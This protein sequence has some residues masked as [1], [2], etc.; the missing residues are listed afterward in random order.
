[1][2]KWQ[3][4]S[5]RKGRAAAG[6]AAL[7]AGWQCHAA[8][9]SVDVV[10]RNGAPLPDVAV[11]ALP[12]TI[13]VESREGTPTHA[14]MDQVNLQ[15]VPHILVVRAGTVIDF[16]NSD[17]V[18]HHVYSFSPTKSFELPLYKGSV[19]PPLTFET[20][21]VVTLGCNIH[22]SMLGYILVVDTPYFAMT[23]GKGR[24]TLD[25]LPDDRYSIR[26]WT[27]RVREEEAPI[28]QAVDLSKHVA[29]SLTF[30][31]PT[32]LFPP[33]QHDRSLTWSDY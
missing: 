2:P 24:A 16:P 5:S 26:V 31:F 7:F 28:E 23:D 22:D 1:M 10:D 33:H 19:Y 14:I 17:N 21:G 3:T 18:N 11:Y 15:F 29:E 8:T 20:A 32:K 13:P 25:G 30:H 27:P 12:S 6:V 9:L 4:T